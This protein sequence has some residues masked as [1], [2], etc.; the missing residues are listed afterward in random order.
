MKIAFGMIVFNSDFVLQEV[1]ESVYPYANQ[2]LIAEG[3]VSFW[4]QK[5]FTTS[6][7]RTNE[8]ID[9]FPDPENKIKITHGQ[10]SEK[11][12]QCNAYMKYMS[13]DNDYVWNLDADEVFKP[14][15]IEKII[16]LLENEKYT[17]VGFKSLSF[18]G[19]FD[20]YL[21]GFEENAEFARIF[22]TYPNSV[23]KTHRPPTLAH[24]NVLNK[25][26]E[27]HLDFNVLAEQYNIRMYHYSYVFPRQVI[28]KTEYYKMMGGS[29][30]IDNYFDRVWLPWFKGSDLEKQIIEDTF[31]GVHEW[32]PYRRG[33]CRT[34]IFKGKHPTIIEKNK[35]KIMKQMEYEK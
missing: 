3:P 26:P 2:I 8:I 17:S 12:N 7:D 18:F 34:E 10:Y 20:K 22:K 6:T 32:M 35:L 24:E 28:E 15:D 4:Q 13:D 9:N 29:G 27:K 1:L 23:W 25:L 14:E 19:G 5:G 33:E 11:D 21:T 30:N 31:N 16:D